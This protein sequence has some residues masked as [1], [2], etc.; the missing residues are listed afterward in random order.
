MNPTIDPKDYN[1]IAKIV[2]RIARH[3]ALPNVVGP[4]NEND[5]NNFLDLICSNQYGIFS[6]WL[7]TRYETGHTIPIDGGLRAPV[8]AIRYLLALGVSVTDI[9]EFIITTEIPSI[10]M[11]ELQTYRDMARFQVMNGYQSNTGTMEQFFSGSKL[12]RDR[13]DAIKKL[14][15]ICLYALDLHKVQPLYKRVL[16]YDMRA[17]T[18]H[19]E[20]HLIN[21]PRLDKFC[22][23]IVNDTFENNH[24]ADSRYKK[25]YAQIHNFNSNHSI[26]KGYITNPR[27]K[28]ENRDELKRILVKIFEATLSC[29]KS[30]DIG[31]NRLRYQCFCYKE[32]DSYKTYED[33]PVSDLF[34]KL[35]QVKEYHLKDYMKRLFI[36][37]TLGE[38]LGFDLIDW[39]LGYI[40]YDVE[41]RTIEEEEGWSI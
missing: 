28:K 25:Y 15:A 23:K 22:E 35:M 21:D 29:I 41:T 6:D 34:I 7:F 37:V 33:M 40:N 3:T 24:K 5:R 16:T 36:I 32:G 11:R 39:Y 12:Q 10:E 8:L 9:C 27:L 13:I 19:Y 4:M 1:R 18:T 31:Y 17:A 30:L 20:H 26:T 2:N 14:L 38:K